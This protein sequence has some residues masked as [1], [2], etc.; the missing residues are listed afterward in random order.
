MDSARRRKYRGTKSP[1]RRLSEHP[2]D[3]HT[4][5][6]SRS[7]ASLCQRVRR[8]TRNSTGSK[9]I[10]PRHSPRKTA[11]RYFLARPCPTY[12]CGFNSPFIGHELNVSGVANADDVRLTKVTHIAH[13][14]ELTIRVVDDE[15]TAYTKTDA[16]TREELLGLAL[17][18]EGIADGHVVEMIAKLVEVGEAPMWIWGAGQ[19]P[20]VPSYKFVYEAAGVEHQLLCPSPTEG[21]PPDED[22]ISVADEQLEAFNASDLDELEILNDKYSGQNRPYH[23]V[24]FTGDR[25]DAESAELVGGAPDDDWFNIG[26]AGSSAAKLHL[27]AHTSAA[28]ARLP[29]FVP[30]PTQD[31]KQAT[32]YAFT[33]TYCPGA[34]RLTKPGEP[35]RVAD[36]RGLLERNSPA[37]FEPERVEPWRHC[38]AQAAQNA[39]RK[40]GGSP[41]TQTCSTSWSCIAERCRNAPLET[42]SPT[43]TAQAPCSVPAKPLVSFNLAP[44]S[45]QS[46]P[47]SCNC[48]DSC[49]LA[50]TCCVDY[51]D[52]F[53]EPPL[54]VGHSPCDEGDKLASYQSPC[55]EEICAADSFCCNTAWDWL[56]VEHV[57]DVCGMSCT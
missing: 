36:Y 1:G 41:K 37:S 20:V 43:P 51:P 42:R 53:W 28:A 54:F 21:A 32:L 5:L 13:A 9:L 27:T 50:G 14:G 49:E 12:S 2:C 47:D 26:C 52:I 7:S 19:G 57:A 33:G 4:P 38:G 29:S 35:I 34:P 10:G 39:C 45:C 8:P 48:E 23:A 18:L 30:P 56:C 31:E 46:Q 16:L 25:Y 22:A 6:R 44:D 11:T 40:C 55:V 3:S 24:L 15:L 17:H